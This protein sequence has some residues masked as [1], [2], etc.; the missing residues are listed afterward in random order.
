MQLLLLSITQV[1]G[2]RTLQEPGLHGYTLYKRTKGKYNRLTIAP[3][4][5]ATF[6]ASVDF[7]ERDGPTTQ[8]L[9]GILGLGG[10]RNSLGEDIKQLRASSDD[11]LYILS[12]NLNIQCTHEHLLPLAVVRIVV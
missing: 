9:Q 6:F 7:P 3:Y 5:S 1:P 11:K 2:D 10:S 8:T 4:L 12:M